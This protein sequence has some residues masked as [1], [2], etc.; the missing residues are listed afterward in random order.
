MCS[1][2]TSGRHAAEI[3]S[4]YVKEP[5]RATKKAK[6]KAAEDTKFGATVQND[7]SELREHLGDLVKK[8]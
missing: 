1:V 3:M 2:I 5:P 8:S 4:R 7:R 6:G